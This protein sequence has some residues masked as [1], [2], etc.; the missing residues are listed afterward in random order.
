MLN[1]FRL[2][3]MR[4][5]RPI[6]WQSRPHLRYEARD[7]FKQTATPWILTDGYEQDSGMHFKLMLDK[8]SSICQN[9]TL[10]DGQG[11]EMWRDCSDKLETPFVSHVHDRHRHHEHRVVRAT[12]DGTVPQ[13]LAG[14]RGAFTLAPLARE[15]PGD[16]DCSE[17]HAKPRN[18]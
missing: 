8:I 4:R 15:S 10:E 13:N 14:V 11:S 6:K 3:V 16:D 2:P 12:H 1:V 17:G 5:I 9:I 18:G 7:L